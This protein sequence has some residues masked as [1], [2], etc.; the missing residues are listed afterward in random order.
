V[1][2]LS[3][4]FTMMRRE[5]VLKLV[6]AYP[7][8]RCKLRDGGWSVPE[9]AYGYDLFPCPLDE[10]GMMLSEDWG[11]NWLWRQIGGKIWCLPD[12]KMAHLGTK[13]FIGKLSDYLHLLA[14][15]ESAA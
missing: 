14:K 9:N 11:M 12:C 10:T 6:A 13:P 1:K 4:G 5:A 8:R 2:Y 7:E 15:K 3:I